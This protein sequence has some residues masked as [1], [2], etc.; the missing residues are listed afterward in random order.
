M[1]ISFYKQEKKRTPFHQDKKMSRPK[2]IR[3]QKRYYTFNG[4]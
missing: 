2:E 1:K 3:Q 4:K